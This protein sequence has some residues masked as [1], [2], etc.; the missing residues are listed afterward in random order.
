[1]VPL[2]EE[3]IRALSLEKA[4]LRLV[5]PHTQEVYV[6]IRHDVYDLTCNIIGGKKGQV[7]DDDDDD[8]I[9]KHS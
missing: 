6:L 9:R 1:M 4:P 7:W 2:T 8:L 3:Q 5:N